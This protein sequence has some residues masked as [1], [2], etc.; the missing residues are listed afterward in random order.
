MNTPFQ[1]WRTWY[2]HINQSTQSGGKSSLIFVHKYTHRELTKQW[3]QCLSK[4]QYFTHRDGSTVYPRDH[5]CPQPHCP[6]PLCSLRPKHTWNFGHK[7]QIKHTK[8]CG[9]QAKKIGGRTPFTCFATFHFFLQHA[10]YFFAILQ[11]KP[12]SREEPKYLLDLKN[13]QVYIFHRQGFLSR[14][15]ALESHYNSQKCVT[16]QR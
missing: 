13:C 1:T 10:V 9:T 4:C 8:E 15:T 12:D 6:P 7:M 2:L 11:K 3:H 16:I 5:M 14:G